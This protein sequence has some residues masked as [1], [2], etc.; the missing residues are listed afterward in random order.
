[1]RMACHINEF[2]LSSCQHF[3]VNFVEKNFRVKSNL[4]ENKLNQYLYENI[5]L[6]FIL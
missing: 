2:T 3:G 4:Y 5:F 6:I 1:M